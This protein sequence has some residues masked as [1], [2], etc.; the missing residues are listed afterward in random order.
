MPSAFLFQRPFPPSVSPLSPRLSL[1]YLEA[2]AVKFFPDV[3]SQG[4]HSKLRLY[5]PCDFLFLPG[6]S[7]RVWTAWML[8]SH[9]EAQSQKY[10]VR[11]LR[12]III[13]QLYN[14]RSISSHLLLII[15]LT[16]VTRQAEMRHFV[17]FVLCLAK[18]HR[19]RK[20]EQCIKTCIV[21][22]VKQF[23]HLMII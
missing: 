12:V 20:W 21:S 10:W 5:F 22:A 8:N 23:T 2:L 15:F 1:G 13:K 17:Y 6:Q 16:T 3:S 7:G 18:Y 11:E 4:C 14:Q 9:L 19:T